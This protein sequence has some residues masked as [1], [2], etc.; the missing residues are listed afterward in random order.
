MSSSDE[1]TT[2][3]PDEEAVL[4]TWHR[5]L[6]D[7]IGRATEQ[8]GMGA[9]HDVHSLSSPRV[10]M[11][12]LYG[13]SSIQIRHTSKKKL[14]SLRSILEDRTEGSFYQTCEELCKVA[15]V[16]LCRSP[17]TEHQ[18]NTN[19]ELGFI[20]VTRKDGSPYS[21]LTIGDYRSVCG[22]LD[23]ATSPLW[24]LRLSGQSGEIICAMKKYAWRE[25]PVEWYAS[26]NNLIIIMYDVSGG[27]SKK[28]LDGVASSSA[29]P[30]KY[31]CRES[32]C[33]VQ[34]GQKAI[35]FG[36]KYWSQQLISFTKF[37]IMIDPR[38]PWKDSTDWSNPDA[39]IQK[40][41][42]QCVLWI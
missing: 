34:I 12:A 11:K 38:T 32:S 27:S 17:N 4:P 5:F 23:D 40:G 15:V 30:S 26:K 29:L 9:R 18:C 19:F 2:L 8:P 41:E 33:H 6:D 24:R 42:V 10:E 14:P 31:L 7:A 20:G 22:A 3:T 36:L 21:R 13:H 25:D 35:S 37:E 16:I 28:I 1:N 39:S